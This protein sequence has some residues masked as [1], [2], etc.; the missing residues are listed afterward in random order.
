MDA[1]WRLG[2][3]SQKEG[4]ARSGECEA[5]CNREVDDGFEGTV[6]ENPGGGPESRL[7][8]P[9]SSEGRAPERLD[10]RRSMANAFCRYLEMARSCKP[11]NVLSRL[12]Y[13][14]KVSER[15]VMDYAGMG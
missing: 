1:A 2:D 15:D 9:S 11:E 12:G 6:T 13:E 3:G 8:P 10:H 4:L 14:W 7:W 5:P